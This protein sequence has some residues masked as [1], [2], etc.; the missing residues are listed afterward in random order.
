MARL[1]IGVEKPLTAAAIEAAQ[2]L[3]LP[4]NRAGF[5]V[6]EPD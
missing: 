2:S 4:A 6:L 5:E 1:S 3:R